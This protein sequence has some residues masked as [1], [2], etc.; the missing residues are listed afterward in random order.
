[1][2]GT[3]M[4]VGGMG[5]FPRRIVNVGLYL[6]VGESFGVEHKLCAISENSIFKVMT[7]EVNSPNVKYNV[8]R[9]FGLNKTAEIVKVRT[10]PLLKWL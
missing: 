3:V 5:R 7:S 2:Q 8:E 6:V 1:V 10:S 9:Y 4:F